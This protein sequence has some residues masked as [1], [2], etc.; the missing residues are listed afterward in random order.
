MT[1]ERL[2]YIANHIA[3]WT[4]GHLI[5]TTGISRPDALRAANNAAN[6]AAQSLEQDLMSTTKGQ[7]ND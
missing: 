6:K 3:Q 1:D 7:D 2:K 5:A 4:Y